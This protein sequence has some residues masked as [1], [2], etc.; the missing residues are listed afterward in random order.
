MKGLNRRVTHENLY[1]KFPLM[2]V[3]LDGDLGGWR[4]DEGRGLMYGSQW[5][6]KESTPQKKPA[7]F[8][9]DFMKNGRSQGLH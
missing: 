4:L 2:V 1:F 5:D 9:T 8:L 3:R 7:G 6:I